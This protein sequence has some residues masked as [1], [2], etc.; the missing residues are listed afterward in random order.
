MYFMYNGFN[1]ANP[2]LSVDISYPRLAWF[3]RISPLC[4]MMWKCCCVWESAL[5][6]IQLAVYVAVPTLSSSLRHCTSSVMVSSMARPS[7]GF[8]LSTK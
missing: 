2:S 1:C 3:T 7:E 6:A 4:P 5:G 8:N